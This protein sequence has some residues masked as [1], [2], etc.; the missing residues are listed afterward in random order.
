MCKCHVLTLFSFFF[1]KIR[2]KQQTVRQP[3]DTMSGN[4]LGGSSVTNRRED[5]M[6]RTKKTQKKACTAIK[7]FVKG[8]LS[9][10]TGEEKTTLKKF[11][12]ALS[13]FKHL[14][15]DT[16]VDHD[17]LFHFVCMIGVKDAVEIAGKSKA[18]KKMLQKQASA[19]RMNLMRTL[20]SV[21][22]CKLKNKLIQC[23]F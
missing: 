16:T 15:E 23:K 22:L 7:K 17:F 21:H 13:C 5:E 12:E 14:E 19:S 9:L 3:K 2:V 18:T 8:D 10:K 4:G 11:L 20:R 6:T 1:C